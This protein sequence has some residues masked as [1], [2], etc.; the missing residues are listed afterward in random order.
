MHKELLMSFRI[1]FL[2]LFL[3][4]GCVLFAADRPQAEREMRAQGDFDR[5]VWSIPPQI[6]DVDRCVQS[7][8][9][10]IS[11]SSPGGLSSL[12]FREG[13]CRIAEATVTGRPADFLDAAAALKKGIDWWPETVGRLPKNYEVP[14]APSGL[15][16][17]FG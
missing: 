1:L 15:R 3:L 9:A 4:S 10:A 17:I 12:Y 2:V 11:V 5:V 14:L 8:V 16:V 7:Q 6:P 13:F